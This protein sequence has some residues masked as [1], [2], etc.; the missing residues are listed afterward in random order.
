MLAVQNDHAVEVLGGRLDV[1]TGFALTLDPSGEPEVLPHYWSVRG[2]VRSVV[3]VGNTIVVGI[4]GG[5]TRAY[6]PTDRR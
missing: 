1:G 3:A 6:T 4:D 2:D 5:K